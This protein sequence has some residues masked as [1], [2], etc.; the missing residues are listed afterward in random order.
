MDTFSKGVLDLKDVIYYV[1][2]T[3]LGLF[4][5]ARSLESIRWRA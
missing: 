5:T 1:S 2:M 3:V 4:L